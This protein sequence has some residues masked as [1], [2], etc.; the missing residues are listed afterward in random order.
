[1]A[2]GPRIRPERPGDEDAIHDLTAR[3]FETMPFSSGTE[4][5]IIRALRTSGDLVLSLVAEQDG[6]IV[7]H[8]AFS[9]ITIDD[10]WDHW[11]GL[12]PISVLP[13]LQRQGIGKRMI[14]EGLERLKQRGAKGC[15]LVGAPEVYRSSSFTSDGSLRYAGVDPKY[16]QWVVFHG[17]APE[18]EL[19]FAPAF[20]VK[21]E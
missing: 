18:G 12:G 16:V 5:A 1:M 6:A 7:G 20:D 14:Q 11:F 4:P 15:A 9:S 8:V 19:T 21:A 13:E 2:D 3:A 17:D 10:T